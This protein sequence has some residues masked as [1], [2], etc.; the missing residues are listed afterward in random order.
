M[1]IKD[2]KPFDYAIIT[3][4]SMVIIFGIMAFVFKKNLSKNPI[5]KASKIEFQVMMRG[6]TISNGINPFNIGSETFITIRNVPYTKLKIKNVL[7]DS[8]KI[9]LPNPTGK[10]KFVIANDPAYPLLFDIIVTLEDNA[11]ITEDGAVVGGN[12]IKMGVPIVLEG[13]DYKFQGVVSSVR[14]LNYNESQNVQ[15]QQMQQPQPQSQMQSSVQQQAKN[16]R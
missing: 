1:N 5:E 13:F 15:P 6:V 12:K 4:V 7:S 2:V 11:D 9:L 14:I 10:E 8:K 3:S 16:N